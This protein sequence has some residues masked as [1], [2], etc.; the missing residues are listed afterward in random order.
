MD[1]VNGISIAM[2]IAIALYND[3]A[4]ATVVFIVH[5]YQERC[6]FALGVDMAVALYLALAIAMAIAS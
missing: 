2:T 5:P 1:I 6:C 4:D 3:L